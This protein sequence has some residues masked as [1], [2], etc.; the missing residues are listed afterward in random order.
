MLKIDVEASPKHRVMIILSLY[1]C[2][3]S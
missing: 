2:I 3:S 1:H